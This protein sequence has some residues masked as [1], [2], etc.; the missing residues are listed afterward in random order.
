MSS[1]VRAGSSVV[2][3]DCFVNPLQFSGPG[4]ETH[5]HRQRH[6]STTQVTRALEGSGLRCLAALA[7]AKRG[8]AGRRPYAP[9]GDH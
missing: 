1:G 9:L 5:L 6:W 2:Q 3:A 8:P 7:N 4:L